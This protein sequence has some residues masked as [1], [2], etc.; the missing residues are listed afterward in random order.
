MMADISKLK[1]ATRLGSPPPISEASQNLDAPEVAPAPPA[2]PLIT[3]T[4]IDARSSR[5]T[6]RTQQFAT[7][8]TPEWDNRIR[9]IAQ[10]EGLL[11]TEVLEKALDAYENLLAQR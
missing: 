10:R 7:R 1:K 6:N 4:R 9:E 3:A 5:K 2:A 11:L 8:V